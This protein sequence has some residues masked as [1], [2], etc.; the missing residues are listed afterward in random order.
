[1]FEANI[2]L[3]FEQKQQTLCSL[4]IVLIKKVLPNIGCALS[5]LQGVLRGVGIEDQLPTI[6]IVAHYDAFGIAPVRRLCVAF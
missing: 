2:A 6:A 1:M 4:E 5:I 3:N